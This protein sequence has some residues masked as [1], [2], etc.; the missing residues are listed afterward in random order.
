MTARVRGWLPLALAAALLAGCTGIPTSGPIVEGPPIDRNPADQV[1]RVIARPPQ[2]GM[3]PTQIIRGFLQASASFE[4][5][6][7]VARQY[8]TPEAA[9]LWDPDAGTTVYDG[10]PET[11]LTSIDVITVTAPQVGTILADGSY[12]VTPP[13]R[14]VTETFTVGRVG[15]E[16]RLAQV[17]P[18]LLL[19]RSDIDRAYRT[20]NLYFFDPAFTTLVPDP[21]FIPVGG[22]GLAT[23]LVQR[24]LAGPSDWLGPA[25]RTAI[26]DGTTL[27]VEAVPVVEGIAQV[28]LDS[29]ARLTDDRTRQA[30]SAQVVWTLRQVSTIASVSLASGGQPLE[31][32]GVANPQP[33]D[34][35]SQYDPDLMPGTATS[36]FV[37]GGRVLRTESDGFGLVPGGAGLGEPPLEGI[38]VRFDGT[39]VAGLDPAGALWAADLAV[40]G[41]T[42]PVLEEQGLSRPAFDREGGLWTIAPE[43]QVRRV[44][45]DGRVND[46]PIEGL[47]FTVVAESLS[48]SRDG[49]RA[50]L[51]V[52]RGPRT[53]LLVAAVVVREGG[54]VL[55]RPRRV[56]NRLATVVDVTWGGASRL[57]AL[58]TEGASTTQAYDIDLARATIRSLPTPPEAI[59]IAAAPGFPTLVGTAPGRI[60]TLTGTQWRDFAV[61]NSPAYPG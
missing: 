51:I 1:I 17:P 7:A 43:G 56:E 9:A 49:T 23:S 46:V 37:T 52:R 5:D 50:A 20:Y 34:S 12:A 45:P 47:A 8:L 14:T 36:Y 2:P 22:P 28:D 4:A 32:P 39:D 55:V 60:V 35:W 15:A 30:M 24:L 16:W 42:V 58:G 41:P 53:V 26:P 54:V 59:R 27:S 29:G 11:R 13:G 19:S 3:D 31:V 48:L 33:R 18:G 10:I 57:L 44:L 38:A 25:V 6:H 21:R 61:G 40:G